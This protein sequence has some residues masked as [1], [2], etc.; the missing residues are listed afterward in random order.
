[1]FDL[2]GALLFTARALAVSSLR[3]AVA[4]AITGLVFL[5][6]ISSFSFALT[7][8]CMSLKTFFAK[9]A[10]SIWLELLMDVA[11]FCMS[12]T[13]RFATVFQFLD[14]AP[15]LGSLMLRIAFLWGKSHYK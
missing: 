12:S 11:A 1:M 8:E 9:V 3:F 14:C 5:S 7:L 15:L 2:A 6:F 4:S 10:R 13:R